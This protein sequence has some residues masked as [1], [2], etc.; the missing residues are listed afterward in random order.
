MARLNK[1]VNFNVLW[2]QSG[3]K[4][5]VTA[6]IPE[7]W[8]VE[9]PD[10]EDM[11][12]LQYRQ[13][14]GIAY[15][16][17]VGVSEWES[18]SVYYPNQITNR[19]GV[20]YKALQEN[21][22]RDPSTAVANGYWEKLSPSYSEFTTLQNRINS[23]DPFSQYILKTQPVVS[24]SMGATG[25]RSNV[26]PT[27]GMFF[28]G[29]EMDFRKSGTTTASIP[30]NTLSIEDNSK[31]LAT[32]AWVKSLIADEIAKVTTKFQ[33]GIGESIISNNPQNPASSKGYGVW[34]LD[35]QGRSIVG[36][37]QN[38]A[39]PSWTKTVNSLFGT[40][41]N[42]LTSE[43]IPPHK[44]YTVRIG[45]SIGDMNLTNNVFVNAHRTNS[46]YN[47]YIAGSTSP[48]EVPDTGI[49]S[50]PIG[51]NGQPIGNTATSFNNV[52]PSQTKYI[53]TRIA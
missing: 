26:E 3:S 43:N 29:T 11:N 37:S 1:P 24:V 7:G 40:Y 22:G 17:Q 25:F 9:I 46:D 23:S 32:T 19:N 18:S 34:A 47:G 41:T 21:Q 51:S 45:N 49:S 53:W 28:N 35:C 39:D 31:Y 8:V 38:A 12:A 50:N 42:T 2:A 10:F 44:H 52:Q 14:S 6:K 5:D 4:S 13:D 30:P 16:L 33:I 48:N 36:V 15:L 27:T 20:L